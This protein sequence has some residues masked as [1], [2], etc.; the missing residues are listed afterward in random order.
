MLKKALLPLL[1]MLTVVIVS[2]WYINF[3]PQRTSVSTT[4]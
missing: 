3:S 4:Y 2:A 1:G